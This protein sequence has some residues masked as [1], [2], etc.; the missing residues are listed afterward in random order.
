MK[1]KV[2]FFYKD[3]LRTNLVIATSISVRGIKCTEVKKIEKKWNET[4][5]ARCGLTDVNPGQNFTIPF[6]L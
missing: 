4:G 1:K 6:I 2:N 3:P 5:E